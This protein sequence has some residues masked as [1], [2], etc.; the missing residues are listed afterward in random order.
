MVAAGVRDATG[1]VV[2]DRALVH[3]A[4]S[5]AA[6]CEV[7]EEAGITEALLYRFFP[8]KSDIFRAAVHE[9]LERFVHGLSR[10][11]LRWRLKRTLPKPAVSSTEPARRAAP[12]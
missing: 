3:D 5:I 4:V 2:E 8:S 1:V 12:H 6:L 10:W 7:A 11:P 9:P